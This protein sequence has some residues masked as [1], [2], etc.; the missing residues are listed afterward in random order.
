[1]LITGNKCESL[2]GMLNGQMDVFDASATFYYEDT[3]TLYCDLGYVLNDDLTNH[4]Q[5]STCQKDGSWSPSW[6]ECEQCVYFTSLC[7]GFSYLVG[8]T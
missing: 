8:V 4:E 2:P 7:F 6:Q 5:T 3:V 1:M